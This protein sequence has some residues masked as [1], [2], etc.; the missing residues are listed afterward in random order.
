MS[1]PTLR[2][3]TPHDCESIRAIYAPYVEHTAVTFEY[4]LPSAK[5]FT[6]RI[7]STLAQ[8]PY[9]VAELDGKVIGYAYAHAFRGRTA[10]SW[11]A[12]LSIY[13]AP[14]TARRGIGTRLYRALLAL[15]RE[16]KLITAYACVTMPGTASLAFHEAFGFT[17]LGT[18]PHSGFK[19]GCWHDIVWLECVLRERVT[20][21]SDFIPFP[22]LDP[23]R[24]QQI[25]AS[26]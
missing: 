15:L 7:C 12:E 26:C 22:A 8:Y 9:L 25:L 4:T 11:D 1:Q 10:Y 6:E 19:R 2:I 20:P 21:P 16:Q 3:A 24:I 5:E 13:L 14:D 18:F 17:R 23:A